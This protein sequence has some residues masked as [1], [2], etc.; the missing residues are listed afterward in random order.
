MASELE[1]IANRLR[2]LSDQAQQ[3]RRPVLDASRKLRDAANVVGTFHADQPEGGAVTAPAHLVA[4][5]SQAA[6]RTRLAEA[7]L[8]QTAELLRTFAARLSS[9]SASGAPAGTG[10]STPRTVGGGHRPGQGD[11]PSPSG[12]PAGESPPADRT[13][14]T[15]AEPRPAPATPHGVSA[16]RGAWDSSVAPPARSGAGSVG[17]SRYG[18]YPTVPAVRL[19]P[20]KR[21]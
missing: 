16:E 18:R 10:R 9:G 2:F 19:S 3:Q 17:P 21:S 6:D 13:P 7:P 11:V 8:G 20:G 1:R 4:R 14:P 5:L 15:G 12:D